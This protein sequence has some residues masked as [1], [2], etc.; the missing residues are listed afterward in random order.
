MIPPP[1]SLPGR[2]S[3]RSAGRPGEAASFR[4]SAGTRPLIA[5]SDDREPAGDSA[6]LWNVVAWDS[7]YT[8]FSRVK[9]ACPHGESS[10]AARQA[11]APGFRASKGVASGR[12]R[13]RELPR[14]QPSL[15]EAKGESSRGRGQ[16]HDTRFRLAPQT[17]HKPRQSARQ[18][19]FMGTERITCSVATSAS[20]MPSPE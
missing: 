14:D 7:A 8:S 2:G 20:S 10:L 18:I 6:V 12:P 5:R 4:D 16:W 13:S 1:G 19:T 11:I 9:F 15:S 17:G 3:S